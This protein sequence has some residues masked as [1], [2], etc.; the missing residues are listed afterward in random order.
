MRGATDCAK[1]LRKLLKTLKADAG[2]PPRHTAD[3]PITHLIIG[4]FTRDMPESKAREALDR[5]RSLVVDYNEL[6]VTAPGEL[7]QIIGDYPDAFIK[8]E[9]VSRAL[10]KIFAGQH[11]VSLEHLRTRS[12]KEVRDYLARLDG[13][14]AYSRARV[15]LYG[16]GHHAIPLDEAM[17]AY[18]KKHRIIDA[19]CAH[20][21]AQSFLERH[22]DPD[23]ALAFVAALR[24]AAW[25]ELASEIRS[26]LHPRIASI[27]PTR[28]SKNMLRPITIA[29]EPAADDDA[30]LA[31]E[32]D[33]LHEE[34]A[35][36]SAAKSPRTA[37]R[38]SRASKSA[39]HRAS[40]PAA[41]KSK[42]ATRRKARSA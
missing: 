15:A 25:G 12:R 18:L 30:A 35:P 8:C 36:G 3:D 34:A 41:R 40:R 14:E 5:L 26:G 39:S 1:R 42:Q 6:R 21:E 17:W 32:L 4:V 24:K 10:N 33:G 27:P 28:A 31:A 7:A 9:D 19:G 11:L 38:K 37:A 22:I 23:D 20:E 2:K 16:F 13:L 29:S